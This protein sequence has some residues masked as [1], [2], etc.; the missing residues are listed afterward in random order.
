[1]LSTAK[2]EK[3]RHK[4]QFPVPKS[5]GCT[6]FQEDSVKIDNINKI[7]ENSDDDE[8]E[9]NKGDLMMIEEQSFSNIVTL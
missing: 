8:H 3:K 9:V 2:K 5:H 7:L 6:G 4:S 1:M